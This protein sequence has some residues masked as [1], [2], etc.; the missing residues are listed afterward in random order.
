VVQLSAQQ[1]EQSQ[2]PQGKLTL[3]EVRLEHRLPIARLAEASYLPLDTIHRMLTNQPVKRWEAQAALGGVSQLTGI[4]YTL[5][6]IDIVLVQDDGTP[7]PA[8]QT[9]R[10]APFHQ[11][12]ANGKIVYQG[13]DWGEAVSRFYDAIAVCDFRR[14][15]HMVEAPYIRGK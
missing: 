12:I 8:P 2:Q 11:I 10:L 15:I 7:P 9:A 5:D 4:H 6:L 1:D 14:V 3:N 13:D